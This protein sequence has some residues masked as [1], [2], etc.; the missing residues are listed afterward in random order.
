MATMT[1]MA[2]AMT[3]KL[4]VATATRLPLPHCPIDRKKARATPPTCQ[5][6]SAKPVESVCH[7]C[8]TNLG[9]ETEAVYG[10]QRRELSW[11]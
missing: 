6:R 9:P 1:A 8:R 7:P 5:K 10:D 2:T 4:M 11:G 3:P